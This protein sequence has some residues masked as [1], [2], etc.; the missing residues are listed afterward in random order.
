[1]D[2][3]I[4]LLRGINVSG[5]KKIKMD[6]L[7]TML[8]ELKFK[9]IKTYIQSGNVVFRNIENANSKDIEFEIEEKI[10]E[11]YGFEVKTFIKTLTELHEIII[12]NPF[13][14]KSGRD[15]NYYVY[16]FPFRYTNIG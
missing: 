12:N 16:N 10:R 8:E 5:Q 7:K 2:T 1:M 11:K 13:L 14:K 15:I 4:V 3:Y 6:E 9:N